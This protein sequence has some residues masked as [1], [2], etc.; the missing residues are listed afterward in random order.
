MWITNI[1][2]LLLLLTGLTQT[3]AQEASLIYVQ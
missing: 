2:A 3:L 1:F